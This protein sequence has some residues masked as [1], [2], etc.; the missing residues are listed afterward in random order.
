MALVA[1]SILASDWGK[2]E[3]EVKAVSAAGANLIHM[4][5]MDGSFVPPI[6]FG[7][8]F[9]AAA[10]KATSLPLDV[11]LMIASPERQ[12]DAFAK[13]GASILTVHAEACPHLHR[14]IQRIHEL[15]LKAG[16]ALNPATPLSAVD[17]ILP[18]IDL[19]LI[20][21]VNP[22]WGGQSYIENSDEKVRQAAALI[23]RCGRQIHLE[24]DGGI[25]DL[26]AKRCLRAGA[27]I[28]VAGSYVFKDKGKY[29][30]KI[31]ALHKAGSC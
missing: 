26:T 15:G 2:L 6:T 31:D 28:L 7:P 23:Q 4:D 1:P 11:H 14:T 20:M 27:D 24:V 12:L 8:D 25:T 5:V 17:C 19:L 21:T 22:G 10:K 13:A 9:V 18:D 3:E 16:V 29:A 30:E